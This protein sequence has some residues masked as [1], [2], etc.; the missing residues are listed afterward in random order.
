MKIIFLETTNQVV[1]VIKDLETFD[2]CVSKYGFSNLDKRSTCDS[3][4]VCGS[5]QILNVKL[6]DFQIIVLIEILGF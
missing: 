5:Y 3:F 6:V 4:T 1:Y 2:S